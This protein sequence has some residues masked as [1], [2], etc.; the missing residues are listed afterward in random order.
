VPQQK[1][2]LRGCPRFCF[3]K[4]RLVTAIAHHHQM[5]NINLK[6]DASALLTFVAKLLNGALQFT[7]SL[8]RLSDSFAEIITLEIDDRAALAGELTV[9][10]KPSNRLFG[11]AATTGTRDGNGCIV[12]K[13]HVTP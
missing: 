5:Q 2:H 7:P 11:L 3:G 4:A 1:M 9:V 13:A 12:E 6:C 8:V 10:L